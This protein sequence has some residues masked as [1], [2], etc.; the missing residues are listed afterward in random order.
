MLGKK[1]R[2][3]REKLGMTQDELAQLA[4][5]KSRSSI[6]KI[7]QGGNDLPQ[8]KIAM[9]AKKMPEIIPRHFTLYIFIRA[10]CPTSEA[11]QSRQPLVRFPSDS[12]LP[13]LLWLR[14][15]L[16]LLRTARMNNRLQ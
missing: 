16:R 13:H 14:Q 8:T 9:F 12:L 6:N 10:A 4:G 15:T 3:C 11:P 1:I 7:E 2:E 5:Y